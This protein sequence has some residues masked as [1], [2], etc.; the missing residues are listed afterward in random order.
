MSSQPTL[1][2]PKDV[3]DPIIQASITAAILSG[4]GDQSK[5]VA[6]AISSILSQKV[7]PNS[8]Q[9]NSYQSHNTVSWIDW[10]LGQQV[11]ESAKAAIIE[12]L[13]N[14]QDLVKK[15]LTAELSKKNSVLA[16]QLVEAMAKGMSNEHALKYAVSV[17]VSPNHD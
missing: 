14:N 7:D 9:V 8:G 3:I 11:R 13:A 1:H 10:A 12:H 2:I 16:K 6:S 17:T 15:Q 5:V 4:L